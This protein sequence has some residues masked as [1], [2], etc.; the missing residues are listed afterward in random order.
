MKR[1]V[2]ALLCAYS[3]AA[4]AEVYKYVD[5]QGHVTYT[6]VPTKGAQRVQLTPLSSYRPSEM[7]GKRRAEASSD[8][9]A[10][11]DSGTQKQRDTGRRKIL[12]Q[13]LSNEQKALAEAE[14]ALADGKAVRYGNEKNYQKYLDRVNGLQDNVTVHQKNIMA[15]RQ[16]LA[17]AGGGAPK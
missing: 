9:G 7:P 14:K 4:Q 16:E 2:F 3:A 13:E 8:I 10:K 1:L 15:I 5:A 6:N 11:V 17:Q 12:E